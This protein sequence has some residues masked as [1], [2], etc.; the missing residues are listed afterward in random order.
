VRH[1]E[2]ERFAK[3]Y[4]EIYFWNC[5]LYVF[6]VYSKPILCGSILG[7]FSRLL[8]NNSGKTKWANDLKFGIKV[9]GQD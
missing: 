5:L 1:F 6:L 3:D 7:Q 2:K 4:Q 9:I 8:A